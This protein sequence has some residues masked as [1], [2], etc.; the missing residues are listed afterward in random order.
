[1]TTTTK[2]T[3]PPSSRTPARRRFSVELESTGDLDDFTGFRRWLRACWRAYGLKVI[4]MGTTP[5][6]PPVGVK[7]SENSPRDSKDAEHGRGGDAAE[8]NVAQGTTPH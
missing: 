1:M 5:P 6:L 4:R 3:R 2:P 7:R 8:G